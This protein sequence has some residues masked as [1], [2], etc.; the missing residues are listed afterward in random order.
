MTKISVKPTYSHF[1][2]FFISYFY[3][4]IKLKNCHNFCR[5]ILLVGTLVTNILKG[6]KNYSRQKIKVD[7]NLVWPLFCPI[8]NIQ[9]V[10]KCRNSNREFKI[11]KHYKKKLQTNC[12]LAQMFFVSKLC[13]QKQWKK[14]QE[15]AS[16][17]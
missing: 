11:K 7:E 2:N 6:D 16:T 4:N 15:L 3:S 17:K 9:W 13:A 12:S 14:W 1:Q 5:T 10:T 8:R